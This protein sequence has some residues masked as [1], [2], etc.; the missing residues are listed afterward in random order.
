MAAYQ[1]VENIMN[2]AAG[3]PVTV[4]WEFSE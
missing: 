3:V 4:T 2:Q 1:S